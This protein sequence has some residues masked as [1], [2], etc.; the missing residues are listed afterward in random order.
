CAAPVASERF[1][2]GAGGWP[3]PCREGPRFAGF[4]NRRRARVAQVLHGDGVMARRTK[5]AGLI[6]AALLAA[7]CREA[8]S[9][10]PRAPGAPLLEVAA[11]SGIALDQHNSAS[12]ERGTVLTKGFNPTNPQLGDAIV[13]TFFW[14]S[15]TPTNIIDSVVDRQSNLTRRQHLPAG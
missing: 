15:S 4:R 6:G 14:R 10:E 1:R 11:A 13:A 12:G 7:G 8:I 3:E 9:P 5:I 2:T